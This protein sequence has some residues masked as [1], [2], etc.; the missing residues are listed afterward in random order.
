[1]LQ[2]DSL[3]ENESV[4]S[5]VKLNAD[6]DTFRSWLISYVENVWSLPQSFQGG[7]L[8]DI[9]LIEL[10]MDSLE[11]HMMASLIEDD[12]SVEF[13]PNILLDYHTINSLAAYCCR[14]NNE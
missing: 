2:K 5:P 9:D 13:D 11:A 14:S 12:F 1:M 4:N 3:S 7:S 10:G 6:Y 8:D